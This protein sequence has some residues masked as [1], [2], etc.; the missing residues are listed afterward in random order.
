MVYGGYP[1]GCGGLNCEGTDAMGK[2]WDLFLLSI[3]ITPPKEA[4]RD[5]WKETREEKLA[6]KEESLRAYEGEDGRAVGD[7]GAR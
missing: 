6:E 4:M 3:G 1:C 2:Y 5:K 7:E